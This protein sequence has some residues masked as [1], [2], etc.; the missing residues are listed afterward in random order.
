MFA[1]EQGNRPFNV[2]APEAPAAVNLWHR[3]CLDFADAKA[4][5]A[6]LLELLLRYDRKKGG[7]PYLVHLG[8]VP[9][10]PR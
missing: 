9:L 2:R 8:S 3:L 1:D 10:K 7:Q 4:F 6:E 5:Q